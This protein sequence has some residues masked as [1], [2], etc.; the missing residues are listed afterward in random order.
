MTPD[1]NSWKH[2]SN[3]RSDGGGGS[4]GSADPTH[5]N[6]ADDAHRQNQSADDGAANENQHDGGQGN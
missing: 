5:D 4:D 1:D 2:S 3:D 6:S